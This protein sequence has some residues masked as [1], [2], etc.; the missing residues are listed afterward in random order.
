[1][2]K[3]AQCPNKDTPRAED[4]KMEAGHGTLE[5][6]SKRAGEAGSAVQDC[7]GRWSKCY[8]V[9]TRQGIRILTL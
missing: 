5:D 2:H 3:T 6:V 9:P 8:G 1:M 7:L 4:S